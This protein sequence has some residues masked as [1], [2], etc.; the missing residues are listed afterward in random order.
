LT[1]FPQD[2]LWQG[3]GI[4]GYYCLGIQEMGMALSLSFAL[5]RILRCRR[6]IP[7]FSYSLDGLPVILGDV[8][9]QRFHVVFDLQQDAV[10]FGPLSS[11]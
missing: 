3:A 2:Y 7:S 4:P 10:G 6:L 8:L 5:L 1:I 11:C 9:I